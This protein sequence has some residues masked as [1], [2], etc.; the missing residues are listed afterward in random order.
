MKKPDGFKMDQLAFASQ[1][2]RLAQDI[3]ARL[4]GEGI[5]ET[6]QVVT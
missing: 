5:E 3:L 2:E 4:R 6:V 1:G